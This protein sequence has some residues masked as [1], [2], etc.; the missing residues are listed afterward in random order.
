ML[1]ISED[2]HTTLSRLSERL[3]QARLSKHESQALFAE[4]I[5]ISRQTYSK[6]EKGDPNI[7]IGYWLRATWLLSKLRDW[8]K[9]LEQTNLFELYEFQQQQQKKNHKRVRRKK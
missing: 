9:L 7:A 4:R 1:Y 5:G 6:M 2:E 3:K 8:E